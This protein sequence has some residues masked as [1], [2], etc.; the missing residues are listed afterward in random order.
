[1]HLSGQPIDGVAGD[2]AA[3]TRVFGRTQVHRQTTSVGQ[4]QEF[5]VFRDRIS[6]QRVVSRQR[7]ATG[8]QMGGSR[9]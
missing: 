6:R 8:G 9:E 2:S 4:C 7:W 5:K 3:V 1:M